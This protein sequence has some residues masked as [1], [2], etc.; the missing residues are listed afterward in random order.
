M[1]GRALAYFTPDEIAEAF[2]A[3]HGI[4]SPTQLRSMLKRDR[5]DLVAEFRAMAPA[6]KPIS[7]QR[8][9]PR[10]IVM[11]VAF[12]L[13]GVLAVTNV[14]AMLTPAE[15]PIGDEPA[16]ATNDVLV[17]MAQ[18]VPSAAE[19]PCIAALPVGW[20]V[21]GVTVR[22]RGDVR[23]WLDSDRVGGHAVDVRL[24]GPGM[25]SIGAAAEVPSDETRWRRFDDRDSA[26]RSV[27]TYVSD[28]ACVQYEFQLD[29]E[30][31]VAVAADLDVALGFQS[32]ASLVEAV[33][34]RSGLV[35]CGVGAP[36][37]VGAAA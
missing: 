11:A 15:L 3:A 9:G 21:G 22:A 7:L 1:Y 29:D 27:R 5:R 4:A 28:G 30:L 32:R 10:R 13:L 25:C 12:A 17:L 37:C 8:W 19:V 34:R 18:A 31:D 35:L 23:F 6:R 36:P 26:R 16:C 20:S 2:A 14:Y 24:R 33:A